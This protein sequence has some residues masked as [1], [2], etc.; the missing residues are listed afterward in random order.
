MSDAPYN[1]NRKQFIHDAPKPSSQQPF[2]YKHQDN[3]NHNLKNELN[4]TAEYDPLQDTPVEL[5]PNTYVAPQIGRPTDI[6][7]GTTTMKVNNQKV[8]KF[9]PHCGESLQ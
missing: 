2:M 8:Y 7:V 5:G 1:P 3:P 6:E 9:C 4:P